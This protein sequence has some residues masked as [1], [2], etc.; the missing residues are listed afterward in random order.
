MNDSNYQNWHKF[1][2]SQK[3]EAFEDPEVMEEQVL[4]PLNIGKS[5]YTPTTKLEDAEKASPRHQC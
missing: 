1:T 4:K 5:L 2:K 3:V